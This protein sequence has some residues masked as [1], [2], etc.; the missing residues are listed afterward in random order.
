MRL[1]SIAFALALTS[2][3]LAGAQPAQRDH[4]RPPPSADAGPTEAP[5]SPREERVA[6]RKGFAWIPGRWDWR[7][8]WEWVPGHWERERAGK[9]WRAGRWERK[10]NRWVYAA[11]EWISAGDTSPPPE[12]ATPAPPSPPSPP[13]GGPT[14]APPPP[15]AE[16]VDARPGFVWIPGEW[17]W[18]DDN[19]EWVPGHFERERA[20]KRWNPSRW[21]QRD[22]KWARLEGG[23]L[24]NDAPTPPPAPAESRRPG[25]REWK[26]ERPMVSGYFPI[27]GKAGSRIVI[28]GKN[29][30]AN[31]VIELAGQPVRAAKI[32]ADRITFAVPAGAAS[33]SIR[34]RIGPREL[35]VGEFE[36]AAAYDP[37]AEQRRI[38]EEQ[39]KAAEA[40]WQ[41]RQAQLAKDRAAREAAM[42]KA[43][44]ERAATRDRRRAE[45]L[46]ELQSRWQRAFLAA[47]ETQDELTLHAQRVAELA[48]AKEVAEVAGNGKLV[49]RIGIAQAREDER[50]QQRMAALEASFKGRGGQP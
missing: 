29:F 35:P 11:G 31:A 10:D 21:E 7:G 33:G 49:V 22:G 27:K 2:P 43:Q 40:E 37:I 44:E 13:P 12:Q 46:A 32:T 38:E 36:V 14:A 19:W 1:L 3:M 47:P 23:W 17:D 24:D 6:A 42:R 41:T 48:R 9:S 26:L 5:P 39:R 16:K 34:V 45:R 28:R 50:H 25:K 20:G 15:R 4:R 8:K 18:R 30:P